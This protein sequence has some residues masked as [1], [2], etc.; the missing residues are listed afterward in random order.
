MIV[1]ADG[2]DGSFLTEFLLAKGHKVAAVVKSDHYKW[3]KPYTVNLDIY[4][5]DF[6]DNKNVNY[7]MSYVQPD[8]VYNLA[9]YSNTFDPWNN[10]LEVHKL[11][12]LI[13]LNILEY[14]KNT[15]IRFFQA[16]SSNVFGD[17]C[18]SPQNELTLPAPRYVYGATKAYIQEIIDE[19]VQK[20]G[21]FAC[22]GILYSHESERRP[23]EFVSQ[24]IIRHLVD[25]ASNLIIFDLQ[26]G[27]INGQKEWG[28]AKE[29]IEAF[30]LMLQ[31][32]QPDNFIIGN[33]KTYSVR[34]FINI[35]YQRLELN[36]GEHIQYDSNNS[37]KKSI[38]CADAT[39]AEKLLGWKAQTDIHKLID[40][41]ISHEKKKRDARIIC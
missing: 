3:L 37:K 40:I 39:K 36:C 5:Y 41:M 19:Y 34:D 11:N 26:L 9:G 24:K 6:T 1:G 13:P 31:Q 12:T 16:S 14:I 21:V 2:Q 23:Y 28:Y 17:S 32:E 27:D 25:L 7:I 18:I 33:G 15:K 29:Y 35:A 8:E 10:I 20:Y 30:Y 4:N 22:Y 38:M